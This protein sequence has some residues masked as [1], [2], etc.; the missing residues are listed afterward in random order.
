MLWFYLT[1]GIAL[2]AIA[3]SLS[4]RNARD[5]GWHQGYLDGVHAANEFWADSM[6]QTRV[7]LT[8]EGY[9]RG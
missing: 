5:K 1:L 2:L 9:K 4:I 7:K 8:A 3:F 6:E